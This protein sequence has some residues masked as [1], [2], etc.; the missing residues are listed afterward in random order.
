MALR[1]CEAFDY[2]Q[3]NVLAQTLN[4]AGSASKIWFNFAP[5]MLY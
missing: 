5:I 3:F 2:Q 1:S 4:F